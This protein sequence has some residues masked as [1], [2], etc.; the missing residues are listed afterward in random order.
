ME[1][2]FKPLTSRE[3]EEKYGDFYKK[4]KKRAINKKMVP[5]ELWEIIPYAEIW[6]IIDDIDREK[7]TEM[8]PREALEDL[9]LIIERYNDC[10]DEW[11]A[12]NEA[13]KKNPSKEYLCFS[14]MRMAADYTVL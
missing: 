8:A 6:G 13:Y 14:A 11:L 4:I 3:M 2:K 7:L 12:G 1:K 5:E 10:L 9:L